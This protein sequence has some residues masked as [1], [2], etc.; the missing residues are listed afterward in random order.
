MIALQ[1][2]PP[3]SSDDL[4]FLFES[5]HAAVAEAAKAVASGWNHHVDPAWQPHVAED[6]A[7]RAA[8]AALAD[9]GVLQLCV[10]ADFSA[11]R[12]DVRALCLVR[13]AL[14]F[15]DGLLDTAF[16]MQ[17]LGSYPV[18]VAGTPEQRERCLPGIVAGTRLGAFALSEPEAGS[19]VANMQCEARRDG[20]SADAPYRLNGTK[21]WISNAGVAGQYIVFAT[22]DPALGR[23]GITA[24]LV[25]PE[26]VGLRVE[27]FTVMAP[28]PI[29][30]LHFEDCVLPADRRIGPEGA[31]LRLALQ[32]LDTFRTTVAAAAVGM[33]RR[34]LTEATHFARN[35]VQFGKPIIEQ[36]QI[37][38]SLAESLTELDA[39]RLLVYRAAWSRDVEQTRDPAPVAMAKLYATEAAGRIID[40]A[41]QIHGGRGVMVGSVVERLYRENRALRIYEGTSEVQRVI[42]AA[43][44]SS[45]AGA[46]G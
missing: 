31:G 19:D 44:L 8:A 42:L 40:R 1:P 21:T 7:T 16:A 35:R 22:V 15:V 6:I 3:L 34:A 33:A 28:H 36:Q 14:G 17:G 24:F 13:E 37:G 45:P 20:Q 2:S 9:A 30:T 18:S 32:T 5:H 29:G 12:L 25:E 26:D 41:V 46:G 27:R 43:G 4:P 39:A 38:A 10:P 11:P 23:R